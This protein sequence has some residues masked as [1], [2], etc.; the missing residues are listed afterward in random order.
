[1]NMEIFILAAGK[2]RRYRGTGTLKQLVAIGEELLL[3][4]TVRQLGEHSIRPWVV[5]DNAQ[6]IDS[7]DDGA[8]VLSPTR[9]RWTAETFLSTALLWDGRTVVLL[10]D[11]YFTDAT[12]ARIVQYAG[13][14]AIFGKPSE[15]FAWAWGSESNERVKKALATA[16]QRVQRGRGRGKLGDA[17]RALTGLPD[18]KYGGDREGIFQEVLDLTIDVDT[19]KRYARLLE[20]IG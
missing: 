12:L 17:Y 8:R 1:M 9:S 5:T 15:I 16:V 10:G 3:P 4:R 7:L 6:I 19:E 2:G 20:K 11:V 14:L 18:H 13:P